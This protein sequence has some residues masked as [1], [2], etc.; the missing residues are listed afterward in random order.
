M[1][2]AKLDVGQLVCAALES[3]DATG[4]F[5]PLYA[6]ANGDADCIS[7]ADQAPNPGLLGWVDGCS[8][9]GKGQHALVVGSGLGDDAEALAARG[10]AVTAF[11]IAP[12]A[13]RWSRYR[14][15]R[16]TV[17]YQ[18]ADLFHPP[19]E[20]HFAFHLVLEIYTVQSLPVPL[21]INTLLGIARFVA[22]GGTLLAICHGTSDP[23]G[24]IG[25]PWP[26]TRTELETFRLCGLREVAFDTYPDPTDPGVLHFRAAYHRPDTG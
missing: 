18:V 15:P 26:V 21:R 10:F 4:W 6:G 9:Q 17:D 2:Q 19:P 8:L 1:P 13:I 20:W 16:T 3:G 24:R 22:P 11:D 7:W 12:T 14:F 23:R 25:P 5:E